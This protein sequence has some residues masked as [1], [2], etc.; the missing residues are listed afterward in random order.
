MIGFATERLIEMEVAAR[1]DK[2]K[3][4]AEWRRPWRE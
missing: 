2:V 1:P 3:S 4:H